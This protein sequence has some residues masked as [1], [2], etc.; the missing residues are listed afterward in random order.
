MVTGFEHEQIRRD[1]YRVL[2]V[3]ERILA[4]INRCTQ[5]SH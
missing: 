5:N 2:R 1:I 4:P 3:P